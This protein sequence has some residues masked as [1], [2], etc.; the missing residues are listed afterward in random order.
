MNRKSLLL[1]TCISPSNYSGKISM[2]VHKSQMYSADLNLPKL[3]IFRSLTQTLWLQVLTL[4]FLSFYLSKL[5]LTVNDFG[6]AT[7]QTMSVWFHRAWVIKS[8]SAFWQILSGLSFGAKF[9]SAE[10]AAFEDQQRSLD[11]SLVQSEERIWKSFER[12][13]HFCN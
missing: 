7:E 10:N 1:N 8:E 3:R 2:L 13:I 12:T 5:G 6:G 11:N 4:D 9:K